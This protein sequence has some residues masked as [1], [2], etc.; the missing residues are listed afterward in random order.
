MI[1]R[2]PETA[3]YVWEKS[4]PL[5]QVAQVFEEKNKESI[6]VIPIRFSIGCILFERDFLLSFNGYLAP[7]QTKI[8][9]WSKRGCEFVIP[10][11]VIYSLW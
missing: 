3:K 8:Q 4:L 9:T 7:R 5:N 6:E 2:D 11:K 10:H 1:W